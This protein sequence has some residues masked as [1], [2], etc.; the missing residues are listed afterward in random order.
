M[1]LGKNPCPRGSHDSDFSPATQ[2]SFSTPTSCSRRMANG[3]MPDGNRPEDRGQRFD[4]F[5]CRQSCRQDCTPSFSPPSMACQRYRQRSKSANWRHDRGYIFFDVIVRGLVYLRSKE[6]WEESGV[7]PQTWPSA[8]V[9]V[10]VVAL[11][12]REIAEVL[13]YSSPCL[14]TSRR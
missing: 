2:A 14:P 7:W 4:P 5:A 9:D 12:R 1:T 3:G 10:E 11:K 13:A 8:A 6:S